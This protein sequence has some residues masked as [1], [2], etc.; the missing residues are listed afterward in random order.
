MHEYILVTV[1]P[2]NEAVAFTIVEPFYCSCDQWKYLCWLN[3]NGAS[4]ILKATCGSN[5]LK[6]GGTS[7]LTTTR[8]ALQQIYIIAELDT[9]SKDRCY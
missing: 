7:E 6:L 9:E 3:W 8:R 5:Y 4:L 1:L 2:G